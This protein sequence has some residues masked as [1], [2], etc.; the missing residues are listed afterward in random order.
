LDQSS[1]PKYP[2]YLN[3]PFFN[4]RRGVILPNLEK[5]NIQGV[6]SLYDAYKYILN[7]Q[8]VYEKAKETRERKELI[9]NVFSISKEVTTALVEELLR[10]CQDQGLTPQQ[11]Q[12]LQQKRLQQQRQAEPQQ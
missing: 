4:L 9:Y 1:L 5:L 2:I 10:T 12:Q 7:F 11:L 3:E 6:S 8:S